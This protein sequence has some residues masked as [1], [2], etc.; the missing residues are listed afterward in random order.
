[1]KKIFGAVWNHMLH[2]SKADLIQHTCA[3]DKLGLKTV[4]RNKAGYSWH[5]VT[6]HTIFMQITFQNKSL[7]I[8][9]IRLRV[10]LQA[11]FFDVFGLFTYF[12]ENWCLPFCLEYYFSSETIRGSSYTNTN[13]R[14]WLD[15]GLLSEWQML[16]YFLLTHLKPG[17]D[18]HAPT[19]STSFSFSHTQVHSRG[20]CQEDEEQQPH[21]L[22][23]FCSRH[24]SWGWNDLGSV[25]SFFACLFLF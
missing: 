22:T 1:M 14:G 11:G 9:T 15:H 4:L 6:M 3:S 19:L 2:L 21:W 8:K 23:A 16:A 17:S 12:C 20:R 24:H 7:G 5:R 13:R 25:H 10:D 18:R